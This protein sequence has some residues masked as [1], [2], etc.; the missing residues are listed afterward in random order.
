M[1]IG[2]AQRDIAR[3]YV[4][5]G[6]GV[7]VSS[8]AWFAA[9]FVER[10]QGI[11][12]GFVTLF[13]GG[14]LIYP[15]STL[16]SRF[17]FK[18]AAEAKG[19]VLGRVALESTV[20]MIGGL[21]AAWLFLTYEPDFVFPLAA[22]A[23]GTHYFV[24][25]TIY[26]DILFWLLGALITAAGLASIMNVDVPLGTVFAVALIELIFAAILTLRSVRT[27]GEVR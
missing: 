26:G 9:A 19:N 4:G 18:R 5:G 27:R 11:G 16:L 20:A 13:V 17:A 12:P 25:R 8:L 10:S 6:P 24:F 15:V 23:V 14:F 22:I 7:F 21:F 1:E 2:E 3:A